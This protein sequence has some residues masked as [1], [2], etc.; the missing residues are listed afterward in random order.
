MAYDLRNSQKVKEK[1]SKSGLPTGTAQHKPGYKKTNPFAPNALADEMKEIST[2]S[3][4]LVNSKNSSRTSPDKGAVAMATVSKATSPKS[5]SPDIGAVAM[6]TVSK[7][8]T[9]KSTSPDKSAVALA[10]VTT[11]TSPECTFQAPDDYEQSKFDLFF[12]RSTK[13]FEEMIDRAVDRLAKKLADVEAMLGASLEFE[14]QRVDDLQDN[15]LRLETKVKVLEVE[16]AKL[17]DDA[18]RNELAA[19]KSER[20]SRRNNI[21][22]VGIDEFQP[23][24]RSDGDPGSTSHLQATNDNPGLTSHLKAQPQRSEDCIA[25]AED[26]LRRHFGIHSKVERA[27]R[28]GKIVAG[29]SRHILVK[30]LSY[31]DKVEIMKTARDVLKNEKFFIVDDLTTADLGEKRK[32][33]KQVQALYAQGTRM[34]FYAGKWRLRGGNAYNFETPAHDASLSKVTDED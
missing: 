26:K 11:A 33:S 7:A 34:R 15:Q 12:E 23:T 19:N 4:S 6:A 29:R 20:F 8:T 10:T 21:R 16:I 14:R 28:D 32:W 5:T 13:R 22:I 24:I 18:D 25:I 9:P 31:R 17:R 2:P 30:V 27:H 3:P 1:G